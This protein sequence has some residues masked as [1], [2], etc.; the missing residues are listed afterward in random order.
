MEIEEDITFSSL[1]SK[2]FIDPAG[3]CMQVLVSKISTGLTLF[4]YVQIV[5]VLFEKDADAV[6]VSASLCKPRVISLFKRFD[7]EL[8][9]ILR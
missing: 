5:P 9:L 6:R 7:L 1:F 8:F 4:R 2:R 3:A